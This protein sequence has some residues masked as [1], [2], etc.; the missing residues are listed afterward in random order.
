MRQS[1]PDLSWQ[2]GFYELGTDFLTPLHP[3]PLPSPSLV[4]SSSQVAELIGLDPASFNQQDL[5]EILSGNHP[6]TCT[7]PYASVY[8]G[9]QFGVWAGQLGD[10]RAITLG[11]VEHQQQIFEIQL[12]GAGKTPYSRMGDGRA[13]LRSSIREYLCSEAMAGLNIPTTRALAIT[14]SPKQVVRETVETASVVTRVAPSFIRFGHFE[15][16]ATTGQLEHLQRLADFVISHH[17]KDIQEDQNPYLS[18]CEEVLE[19]RASL[20]AKWK[21]VGFCHVVLNTDNK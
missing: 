19:R 14:A 11:Q 18:L 16:F 7:Q 4:A 17:F 3:S 9:H 21:T 10:G 13:V 12:K 1:L 5:I 8:S 15:H 2:S 20:D 6:I